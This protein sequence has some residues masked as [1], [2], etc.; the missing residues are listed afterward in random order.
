VDTYR[1]WGLADLARKAT[2]PESLRRAVAFWFFRELPGIDLDP[3]P[4]R[5]S[6]VLYLPESLRL[7]PAPTAGA[8]EPAE[9]PLDS[10][11]DVSPGPARSSD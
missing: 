9:P 5:K 6:A 1:C 3:W 4:L 8:S 11:W 2:E 7:D 10:T